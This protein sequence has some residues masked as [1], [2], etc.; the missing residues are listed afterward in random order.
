MAEGT[1]GEEQRRS[2]GGPMQNGRVEATRRW[3]ERA[4]IGWVPLVGKPRGGIWLSGRHGEALAPGV[5]TA[6]SL[7]ASHNV[8]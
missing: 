3:A 7:D 6:M 5:C 4:R 2:V 1:R 8:Q